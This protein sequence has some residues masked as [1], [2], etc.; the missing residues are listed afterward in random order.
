MSSEPFFNSLQEHLDKELPFVAYSKPKSFQIKALLQKNDTLYKI[1]DYNESGFIFA[2]FDIRKDAILIPLSL[3]K[4]LTTEEDVILEDFD[5]IDN[6]PFGEKEKHTGLVRKGVEAINNGDFEKVVLSRYVDVPNI[7]SDFLLTFKR[8]LH[9]Y[10]SAF[11]YCWYHP[12]VGMWLGA[13]PET[14]LQIEGNEFS[15]MALAGTQQYEGIMDVRWNEKEC[16]E[17]QIVTDFISENIDKI[18]ST[19]EISEPET[20]RAGNVLHLKSDIKGRLSEHENKLQKL[21]NALHPTPAVCGFPKI[22]AMQFI[23]DNEDYNREFYAGFLGELNR[24]VKV[25]P[26]TGKLN[27]ENRAFAYNKRASHLFVNLRCVQ[28][29]ENN[30]KIYVGG[31]ITKDSIPEKEWEETIAKMH[32][33]KSVLS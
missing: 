13:S 26:R 11:V 33:I 20:I 22:E 8:L 4:T 17:Q 16:N 14:L 29:S 32:T 27:I 15:T 7:K 12:K 1:E 28:M 25:Q 10:N 23:L 3:S 9:I 2:P 18:T 24:E 5:A 21:I 30:L 31:G 19:L 6:L